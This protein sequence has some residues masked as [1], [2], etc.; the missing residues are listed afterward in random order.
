MVNIHFNCVYKV[1]KVTCPLKGVCS[2]FRPD[3]YKCD[4]MPSKDEKSTLYCKRYAAVT[5]KDQPTH[6]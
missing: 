4:H 3:D 1:K 5:R 6:Q 2:F